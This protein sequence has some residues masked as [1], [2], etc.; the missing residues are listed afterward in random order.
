MT[1]GSI[2]GSQLFSGLSDINGGCNC[3][4]CYNA[5]NLHDHRNRT[6]S[7]SRAVCALKDTRVK[8]ALHDAVM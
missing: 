1:P 4:K 5:I 3:T 8:A 2:G 7:F 6:E